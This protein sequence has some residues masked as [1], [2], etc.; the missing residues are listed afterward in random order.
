MTIGIPTKSMK[1]SCNHVMTP[2]RLLYELYYTLHCIRL[3]QIVNRDLTPS[4]AASLAAYEVRPAF[5]RPLESKRFN[6]SSINDGLDRCAT[7]TAAGRATAPWT[8]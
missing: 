2:H 3:M 7:T 5:L 6:A 1:L 4:K 8:S